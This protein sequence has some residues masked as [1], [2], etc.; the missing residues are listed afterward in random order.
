MSGEGKAKWFLSLLYYQNAF[1]ETL[2]MVPFEGTLNLETDILKKREFLS[3]IGAV[4][5]E[6]SKD[7]YGEYGKVTCYPVIIGGIKAVA[8]VP[9]K[10]T[11]V[12]DIIEIVAEENLRE[13]LQL[14]DGDVIMIEAQ[15]KSTRPKIGLA[16]TTFAR[17]DMAGFAIEILQNQKNVELARYTVPGIKDLPVACK[18]LFADD[19]CDIVIAFGMVGPQPVDKQCSH[20]ASLGLQAVQLQVNKHI[21]EVFVHA[22]EAKTEA[23]L[24]E[25]AKNRATKHTHN[26]LALLKGKETLQPYAGTGRRQGK[27]DEGPIR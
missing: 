7:A 8:V 4:A 19:N 1:F 25:I 9:D 5:I 11:H 3:N 17:I 22:D 24:F 12:P 23:E 27:N 10:S 18:K 21:V 2:H 15:E 13:K 14:K 6:E 26:A 20:E 16:D